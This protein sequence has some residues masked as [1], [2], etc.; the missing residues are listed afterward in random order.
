MCIFAPPIQTEVTCARRCGQT[1]GT[2]AQPGGAPTAAASR[3]HCCAS[4]QPACTGRVR[5]GD[6]ECST[7]APTAPASGLG[8]DAEQERGRVWPPGPSVLCSGPRCVGGQNLTFKV[9]ARSA[10]PPAPTTAALPLTESSTCCSHWGDRLGP[11]HLMDFQDWCDSLELHAKAAASAAAATAPRPLLLSSAAAGE[12][13][14]ARQRRPAGTTAS[15]SHTLTAHMQRQL[16]SA[17]R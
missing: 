5:G 7:P 6:D 11:V 13:G 3:W 12:A 8:G 15:L 17:P 10:L 16:K 9:S 14:A 4:G 1:G 2:C